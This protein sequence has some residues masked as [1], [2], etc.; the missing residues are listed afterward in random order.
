MPTLR[1]KHEAGPGGGSATMR[2][3]YGW[4]WLCVVL[5]VAGLLV[6]SG[7]GSGLAGPKPAAILTDLR[8]LEELRVQFNQDQG[9]PRV[10]L[11][12]APT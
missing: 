8:D 9:V 3:R 4:A 10:I 6:S 5:L 2:G 7:P 12:V 11:L 1:W